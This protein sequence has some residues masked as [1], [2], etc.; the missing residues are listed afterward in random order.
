MK[1][2]GDLG[3]G[4][5]LKVKYTA[6]RLGCPMTWVPIDIMKGETRT[7]DFLGPFPHGA[8]YPAVELDD[9]RRLAKSNAIIRYLAHGTALL[10]DDGFDAGQ[11]RRVAVLGAVQP[12]ALRGGVPLPHASI[13]HAP[14]RQREP[15]RV[16]RGRGGA[17]S[18]GEGIGRAQLA[19]RRGHDDCGHRAAG[20]TRGWR[21]KAA[22][23]CRSA[24][25]CGPGSSGARM[26]LGLE[27]GT[28]D[29]D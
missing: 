11:D 9:G 1:I 13:W 19:R 28:A 16:E 10:P 21:M 22:S 29:G 24:A 6:D 8:G 23:T 26:D 12:R 5:C 25:I 17:G 15:W 7:P 2:Y 14:R 20:R 3:S 4:N 27:F 18:H